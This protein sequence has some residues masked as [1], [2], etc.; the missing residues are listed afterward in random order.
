[1]PRSA[2]KNAS[3]K[4]S[5]SG[6]AVGKD[7][8][9]VSESVSYNCRTYPLSKIDEQLKTAASDLQEQ[10]QRAY[11]KKLKNDETLL[12]LRQ[13]TYARSK[14]DGGLKATTS[15]KSSTRRTLLEQ[16]L[17]EAQDEIDALQRCAFTL[18]RVKSLKAYKRVITRHQQQHTHGLDGASGSSTG[19][20]GME[21]HYRQPMRRGALMM[22]LQQR[23]VNL[24]VW[25]GKIG[26][27]PPPL[28][29]CRGPRQKHVCR[30]GD[31]VA[32]R[33]KA[34]DGD[35][36]WILAEVAG[37]NAD[38]SKYEVDDIDEEQKER[39]VLVRR[40]VIPLPLYRANPL[41][42]PRAL[43]PEGS[44]VLALY[45]QTTCFYRGLV[46]KRPTCITAPTT[47]K[48]PASCYPSSLSSTNCSNQSQATDYLIAFE[49]NT[50]PGGF[51]P[52]LAVPQKYVVPMPE[53]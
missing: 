21:R 22:L 33:V 11:D 50:Y 4:G 52:P 43:F 28:T 46:E 20:N 49:D 12:T 3:G 15:G 25:V 5:T 23:A 30:L 27:V 37:W 47:T 38:S 2:A 41:T 26:Q 14:E 39:H 10:F 8:Y 16:A 19:S 35:E 6:E 36:N 17:R 18:A 31:L 1:M 48:F 44:L 24:P 42:D 32:A 7:F 53:K 45:P 51:S 40:K 9:A 13:N 29:G 34:T